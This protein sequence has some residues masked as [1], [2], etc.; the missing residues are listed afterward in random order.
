MNENIFPAMK[1][2][3]NV[4]AV[5]GEVTKQ[6]NRIFRQAEEEAANQIN[7]GYVEYSNSYRVLNDP[8]FHIPDLQI[9]EPIND[10]L[11]PGI[12]SKKTSKHQEIIDLALKTSVDDSNESTAEDYWKLAN[13]EEMREFKLEWI[14]SYRDTIN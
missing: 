5:S 1:R 6:I 11:K 3:Q 14:H 8:P 10:T 13:D 7:F 9:T 4:L 2:L 12:G